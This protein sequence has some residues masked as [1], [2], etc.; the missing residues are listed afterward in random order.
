VPSVPKAK[1][2]IVIMMEN[3]DGVDSMAQ[4]TFA[5]LADQG[6]YLANS[7]GVRRP[8]QPNYLALTAGGTH[9]VDTN[10][11]VSVDTRH[12]GNL[13]EEAGK[14]WKAYAETYPGGCFL[15]DTSGTYA[16]KHVPFLSYKN[17]TENPARCAR[18][19]PSTQFWS[20][21]KAGTLPDFSLYVPD[22]SNN[23]H[24]TGV[25]FADAYLEAQWGPVLDDP[26]FMAETLVILTY[27]EPGEDGR[28]P[29]YTAFLGAGVRPG[30]KT[31]TCYN[32]YN[33]LRTIEGVLG[34]GSLGA[35]DQRAAPVSGIW[36]TSSST[37]ARD[38]A[39]KRS[40]LARSLSRDTPLPPRYGSASKAPAMRADS[41]SRKA[42]IAGKGKSERARPTHP[43]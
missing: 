2:V 42:E 24:D 8:S 22:N 19:V 18:V 41:S 36:S 14:Q 12:L 25:A 23:G 38:K 11:N 39:A 3:A 40:S 16:R 37:S 10:E 43:A 30:A 27:D 33:V 35:E 5:R 15:G 20:D 7:H 21:Y 26:K 29:I 4:P 13:V 1:R 9:E 6:A 17:V 34:L 31:D 28:A 32:H